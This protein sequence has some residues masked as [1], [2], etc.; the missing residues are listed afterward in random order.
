MQATPRTWT[1]RGVLV[2][3]G[4]LLVAGLV[5]ALTP[6]LLPSSRPVAPGADGIARAP[7]LDAELREAFSTQQV[8]VPMGEV[9][10]TLERFVVITYWAQ[11]HRDGAIFAPTLVT[12]DGLRYSPIQRA[13]LLHHASAQVGQA[14]VATAVFELPPDK[15]AGSRFELNVHIA[16]GLQPV[17]RVPTFVLPDPLAQIPDVPVIQSAM[18]EPGR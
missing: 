17:S 15:I 18:Q 12:R 9:Y 14:V 2:L 6:T 7:R 10:D 11:P 4:C 3:L 13:N 1:P 5:G 8:A 16:N